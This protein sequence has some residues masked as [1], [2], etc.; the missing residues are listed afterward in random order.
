MVAFRCPHPDGKL[1]PEYCE[2]Q[3]REVPVWCCT[4]CGATLPD[5]AHIDIFEATYGRLCK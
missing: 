5:H 1:R 4:E 3:E 2:M